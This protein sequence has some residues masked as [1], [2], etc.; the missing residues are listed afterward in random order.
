MGCPANC[1]ALLRSAV[2]AIGCSG[3]SVLRPVALLVFV[4]IVMAAGGA[5][6][7]VVVVVGVVVCL[8]PGMV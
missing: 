1:A 6:F 2:P 3:G 4:V 8:S 5:G 7:V